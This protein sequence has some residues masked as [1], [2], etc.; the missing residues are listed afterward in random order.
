LFWADRAVLAAL[1]RLL[2]R[3]QLRQLQLLVSPRILLRWHADL[4]EEVPAEGCGTQRRYRRA[5]GS[6][7]EATAATASPIP[8]RYVPTAPIKREVVG[9]AR[10]GLVSRP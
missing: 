4:A 6:H 2:P 9:I 10:L 3:G 8:N 5:A 7:S 1:A